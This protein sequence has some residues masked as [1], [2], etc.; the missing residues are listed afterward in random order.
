M[1]V[2]ELETLRMANELLMLLENKSLSKVELCRALTLKIFKSL[3]AVAVYIA[4]L[5]ND[6]TVRVDSTYGLSEYETASWKNLPLHEHRP[7]TDAIR[8]NQAMWTDVAG[9]GLTEYLLIEKRDYIEIS[10]S[11]VVWPIT[12]SGIPFGAIG[13]FFNKSINISDTA[14]Q[15]LELIGRIVALKLGEAVPFATEPEVT[16]KTVSQYDALTSREEK[17]LAYIGEYLTNAQI[18]EKL[19]FSES[20]IRQDT[21]QIYRKLGVNGREDARNYYFKLKGYS[22]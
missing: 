15:Y 17:I 12:Q 7:V 19:G 5:N 10:R 9:G 3:E 21:I 2:D 1:K 14:S 20:T 11:Q 16:V 22:S 13:L 8:E 18:S 6:G 4:L